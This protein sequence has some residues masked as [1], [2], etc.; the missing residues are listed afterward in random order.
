M[1]SL[2]HAAAAL[3][4]PLRGAPWRAFSAA[5]MTPHE[6]PSRSAETEREKNI[7]EQNIPDRHTDEH[8]VWGEVAVVAEIP[9]EVRQRRVRCQATMQFRMLAIH[10]RIEAKP[11]QAWRLSYLLYSLCC[12]AGADIPTEPLSLA[13]GQCTLGDR[14][15]GRLEAGV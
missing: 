1:R 12:C 8:G 6:A 7:A 2:A 3:V 9:A 13:A 11:G 14:S 4:Q 10:Q 15:A 5:E